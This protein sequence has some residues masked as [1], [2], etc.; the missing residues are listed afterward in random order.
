MSRRCEICGKGDVRGNTILRRGQKKK[1]GGIGQHVTA[2]TPRL[3]KP[4]LQVVHAL[5][6]G[7]HR[8]VKACTKCIKSGRVEKAA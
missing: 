1:T 6:N 5:V 2:V 4:N 3:F 8:Q 7:V